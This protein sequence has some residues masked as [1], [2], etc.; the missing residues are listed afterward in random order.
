MKLLQTFLAGS[1]LAMATS[2]VAQ[3]APQDMAPA[4]GA[5][6]TTQA[7]AEGT[8]PV[9][10]MTQAPAQSA[11]SADFSDEQIEGFATAALKIQAMQNDPAANEQ[12][13]A[14]AVTQSGIDLQTFNAIGAAM[15]SNPEVA[16]RVQT[17]AREIQQ[18]DG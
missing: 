7:P 8:T 16:Q 4:Q 17:A 15:Q 11:Q 3:M 5:E 6:T 14:A 1:A 18:S 12:Q 13:M 2:A 10:R 9:D